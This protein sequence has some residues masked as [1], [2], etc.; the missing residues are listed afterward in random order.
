MKAQ[1]WPE[2]LSVEAKK[3]VDFPP[4][5]RVYIYPISLFLFFTTDGLVIKPVFV[6]VS[7]F[8]L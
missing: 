3:E 5:Q 6:S 4:K 7:L 2:Y 8:F 1:R